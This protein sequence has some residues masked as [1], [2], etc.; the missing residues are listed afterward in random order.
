MWN[1]FGVINSLSLFK[2]PAFKALSV[3]G[4]SQQTEGVLCFLLGG[5]ATMEFNISDVFE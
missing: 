1:Y 4:L 2:C 3:F 5:Q